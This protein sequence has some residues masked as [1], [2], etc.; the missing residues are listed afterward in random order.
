MVRQMDRLLNS[1]VFKGLKVSFFHILGALRPLGE[2]TEM[3]PSL[4]PTSGKECL[5]GQG[6][7]QK[8]QAMVLMALVKFKPM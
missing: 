8:G 5:E 6:Q 1:D 4:K 7:T 2:V 3:A